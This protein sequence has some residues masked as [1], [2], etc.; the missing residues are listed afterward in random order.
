MFFT[1]E[2][3]TYKIIACGTGYMKEARRLLVSGAAKR[4]IALSLGVTV[5]TVK[6][7]I[8]GKKNRLEA[9][10]SDVL[11]LR[12]DWT[13]T[14]STRVARCLRMI[15]PGGCG[16]SQNFPEKQNSALTS[17][18]TK[19]TA[20]EAGL[21]PNTDAPPAN[22][23]SRLQRRRLARNFDARPPERP[24]PSSPTDKGPYTC[25]GSRSLLPNQNCSQLIKRR[26]WKT[27]RPSA[28]LLKHRGA[29]IRRKNFLVRHI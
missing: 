10:H 25:G 4:D 22:E 27:N 3:T 2:P 6:R 15:D 20:D 24:L 14:R 17:H 28:R 21:Q 13:K 12:K 11:N 16:L 23:R 7:L 9:S 18:R 5:G 26:E 8:T 1:R 29:R 19:K